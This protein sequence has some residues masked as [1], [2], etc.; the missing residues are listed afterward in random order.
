MF[1]HA[2]WM[3]EAERLGAIFTLE[4]DGVGVRVR[5]PKK[6]AETLSDIIDK[7]M[8]YSREI[9]GILI[10]RSQCARSRTTPGRRRPRSANREG[11]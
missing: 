11:I 3:K 4:R 7:L 1:N 2:A 6:N 9:A 5:Y 8:R 10:G